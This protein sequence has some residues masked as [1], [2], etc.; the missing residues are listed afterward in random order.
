MARTSSPY[1]FLQDI[2]STTIDRQSTLSEIRRLKLCGFFFHLTFIENQVIMWFEFVLQNMKQPFRNTRVERDLLN[3]I[4]AHVP[5]PLVH[6][7]L[8]REG[9]ILLILRATQPHKNCWHLPG[10]DIGYRETIARAIARIS[11]AEFGTEAKIE[12]LL[13]VCEIIEDDPNDSCRRHS[14]STVY[15]ASISE[16]PLVKTSEILDI[17]F[18]KELPKNIHPDHKKF[19][20]EHKLI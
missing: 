19:I 10:G 6:I 4:R 13:G 20:L 16:A 14:I 8:K 1:S 17:K 11:R 15:E 18:V 2:R 9:A 12:K 3:F 5:L 7:V